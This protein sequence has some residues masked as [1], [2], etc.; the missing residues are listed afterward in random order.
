[1]HT[2]A[3]TLT[4]HLLPWLGSQTGPYHVIGIIPLLAALLVPRILIL[5]M[6]YNDAGVGGWFLIHAVALV[7]AWGG[8]GGS[9]FRRRRSSDL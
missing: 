2:Y 5:L 8:F 3:L 7:L 1:M 9:Q 4:S 6:I